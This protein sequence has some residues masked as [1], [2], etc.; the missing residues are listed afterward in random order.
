M[1]KKL[2]KLCL[3][4]GLLVTMVALAGCGDVK[5]RADQVDNWST[6]QKRGTVVVGLDDSFVPMGFRQKNGKL[7]GF[8]VELARLVFKRLG[9][10][11]SFQTI[12]WSMKETELR[13]GTI[14]MIWNGY[15]KTKAREKNALFSNTYLRDEQYLVVKKDTGITKNQDMKGKVLGVQTG[16]SG[17]Q[18]YNDYPKL[19]KN[20]VKSSVQYDS[21]NNAFMDL[22]ARRIQGLLID[23]V[24]ANYYIAH[25][26]DAD[27][28][29]KI[30]VGYPSEEFAVG[31]RKGD[32]TL[33]K[34]V[35]QE[36]KALAKDGTLDKLAEKWFGS[37][38]EVAYQ[39]LMK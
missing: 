22:N 19:L 7:V 26:K 6:L 14:D 24:Y 12:D 8:D 18:A 32:K 27:S 20:Y 38:S 1:V 35:N 31:M 2:Q 17:Y 36:L 37:K 29:R 16:S 13:N 25:Q 9:L 11:V 28:Y 3:L 10:K 5:K 33:Q 39:D 30:K 4:L 23:S 21:Y 34:K 15:T